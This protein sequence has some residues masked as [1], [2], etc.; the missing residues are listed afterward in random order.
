[1]KLL[2]TLLCSVI[3]VSIASC[4]IKEDRSDCPCVLTIDASDIRADEIY[5]ICS[6]TTRLLKTSLIPIETGP[7]LE[8]N[9]PRGC[10]NVAAYTGNEFSTEQNDTLVIPYGK[11]ADCIYANT[12]QINTD[13]ETAYTRIDLN[14]Q[15]ARITLEFTNLPENWSGPN[16]GLIVSGKTNGLSL[17]DLS[18]SEGE[19]NCDIAPDN[20]G[21]FSFK[22]PRQKGTDL[23]CRIENEGLTSVPI[24]LGEILESI[25][26][27]WT[28]ENLDDIS[29]ELEFPSS[30]ISVSITDWED[31]NTDI[32]L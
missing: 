4:S 13:A 12:C 27:D 10:V 1:M 25:G 3:I 2:P 21:I 18:P 29:L 8:I 5:I 26:F 24:A 20:K 7:I 15:F 6:N 19:F 31:I 32:V 17:N 23:Y 28:K 14:K 16:I 9:V 11:E 22:V 30:V